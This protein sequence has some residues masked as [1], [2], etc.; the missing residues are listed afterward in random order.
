LKQYAD[1]VAAFVND[2][3]KGGTFKHTLI[4]TFSEFG[5]R[6]KQNAANGTVHGAASNV[7]VIA[8]QLKTPGFYNPLSSL[9]DLDASGDLKFTV[10]FRSVYSSILKDWLGVEDSSI[11]KGD[12]PGLRL[13]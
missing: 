3:K 7:F 11:L 10:D 6:V 13:I 12:F 1:A 5:R 8:K 4:L 2:L 9:S